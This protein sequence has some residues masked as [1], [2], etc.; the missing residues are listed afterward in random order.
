MALPPSVFAEV[1]SGLFSYRYEVEIHV[2]T[3]VGGIPTNRNVAEGWIRTKMGL[4]VDDQVR[5]EVEKVMETRGVPPDAAAEE[6][7]LERHLTGFRRDFGTPLARADQLKATTTGFVLEGERKVFTPEEARRTFGELYFEG[8]QVKAGMKEW[9]MIGV[10]SGHIEATKWGRTSKAAKGF[11][12]E[13]VFV[14]EEAI[15]LGITE[16]SRVDQAFVHTFRGTGIKLEEKVDDAILKFTLISDFDFAT[17]DKL[18]FD[19]VFAIGE[20]NGLG[21]SRSQ[22]FGRFST[23]RFERVASDPAAT[24]RAT[25][26]VQQIRDETAAKEAA[27]NAADAAVKAG[28]DA[29]GVAG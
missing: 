19:K 11:F 12:A 10:A 17:K 1:G 23:I 27:R 5:A 14:E 26:R 25:K 22:G 9:L 8:R 15:L 13:H 4:T 18:F 16:A 24:K 6:V 20:R 21:A 28:L 7:A 2:G 29:A 3:L